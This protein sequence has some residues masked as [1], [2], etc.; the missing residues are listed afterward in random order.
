MTTEIIS[1][2]VVLLLP[3]KS[4]SFF[5]IDQNHIRVSGLPVKVK[6][7]NARTIHVNIIMTIYFSLY[8]QK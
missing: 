6:T 1:T 2:S 7:N 4:F 3:E 8:N 5:S